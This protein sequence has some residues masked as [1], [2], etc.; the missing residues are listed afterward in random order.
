[1]IVSHMTGSSV[2]SEPNLPYVKQETESQIAELNR[3]IRAKERQKS[4]QDVGFCAR[5]ICAQTTS[6][7]CCP[8]VSSFICICNLG[9]ILPTCS[10]AL[11]QRRGGWKNWLS[12]ECC[13]KPPQPAEDF[14]ECCLKCV[15]PTTICR[16]CQEPALY[17]ST[18]TERD[19]YKTTTTSLETLRSQK[20]N[21]LRL[22]EFFETLDSITP[23][24]PSP[25]QQIMIE[26]TVSAKPTQK[27]D[28][29]DHPT[30]SLTL[31]PSS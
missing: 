9:N 10:Y 3:E 17:Y 16:P 26:Y 8:I 19:I 27:T 11:V 22:K 29:M 20:P 15:D 30:Y 21:M 31:E 12:A 4:A 25:V 2:L 28:E 24:I 14:L 13:P 5:K 1:M 6:L 18:P 7:L 23:A